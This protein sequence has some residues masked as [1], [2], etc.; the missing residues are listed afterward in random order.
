MATPISIV[1]NEII[2]KL[3]TQMKM[4]DTQ[5]NL[6]GEGGKPSTSLYQEG[7][8]DGLNRAIRTLE[9]VDTTQ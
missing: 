7:L 1:I 6:V 2:D 3:Q 8:K 5:A 4:I 9:Q